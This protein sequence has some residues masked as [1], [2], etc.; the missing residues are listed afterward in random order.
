[1]KIY[2]ID[3]FTTTCGAGNPTVVCLHP[4]EL[5]PQEMQSLAR[6]WS[7]PVSAFVY[8]RADGRYDIRYYTSSTEIP[9]CGHATLGASRAVFENELK[10]QVSFVTIENIILDAEQ[11]ESIIVMTF[12][13]YELAE[14]IPSHQTLHSL[15]LTSYKSAGLCRELETLFIEL[16][17]PALLRR[18]QPD[19][20]AMMA[21]DPSIIEIV[22]TS[23]SDDHAYDYLLRSFCPWIGIDEDPVT[24]SVHS[25]LAGFWEKRLHKKELIAWQ[26]SPNGGRLFVRSFDDKIEL[27]GESVIV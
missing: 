8:P 11:R 3:T 12:P 5:A 19:Y 6:E 16:D 27:G 26:A 24:G 2:F 20:R 25:V 23:R 4:N 13:R 9:A 21:S 22:V 10:Q 14:Y 18:L 17:D 7:V 1:M 15:Q